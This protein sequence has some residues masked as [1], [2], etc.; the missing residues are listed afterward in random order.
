M[1]YSTGEKCDFSSI[2]NS[3]G[4]NTCAFWREIRV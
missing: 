2:G 3:T 1:T 4:R